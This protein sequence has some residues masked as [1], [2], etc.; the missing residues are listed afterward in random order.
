MRPSVLARVLLVVTA[1][2][3]LAL[4]VLVVLREL[5][6]S[7]VPD[8][9]L[10]DAVPDII[11]MLAFVVVGAIVTIKR[12]ENLVGWALS[13][14]GLGLLLGAVFSLYAEVALLAKPEQ[15]L[16]AGAAAAA[17]SGGTWTLLMGGV[18]LLLLVFPSGH[19][20]SP[21]WRPFAIAVLA[22]FALVWLMISTAPGELET[23]F[24]AYENPLA[25]TSNEAYGT[26]VYVIILPCLLSI[27]VAAIHLLTRFRRSHGVE[28]QQ[29][30]WFAG[31]AGLLILT[32]PAQYAFDFSGVAGL[33]FTIALTALPISIGIAILRYHLYEF[34]TIIRRTLVYGGLSALLAGL[35]FGIVLALQ[36]VFSSFAGGSDLAVAVST[37]AVAALFGPARRRLQRVVD[38]RFYRRRYD[39]R[40][41]LETFSARLRDEIDLDALGTELRTVVHETMQPSDVSLW[42]RPAQEKR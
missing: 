2:L 34:D 12:P 5:D 7:Y 32:L 39:A 25:V 40:Q 16:P 30:K 9:S 15:E 38:R 14:A 42:L 10:T 29:F 17:I 20:P 18:F 35:Y 6:S 21:R 28:R 33:V 8:E 11:M 22:G 4:I 41:T 31:S 23:P 27:V 26:A 24:E 19:V 3:T 37:L 13:L 1:L 36:Q